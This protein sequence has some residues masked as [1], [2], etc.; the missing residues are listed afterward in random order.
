MEIQH[1]EQIVSVCQPIEQRMSDK[2]MVRDS[3]ICKVLLIRL[4]GGPPRGIA[5]EAIVW[6]VARVG[7]ALHATLGLDEML[8]AHHVAGVAQV[9]CHE[10]KH[11]S[12]RA[13]QHRL[14]QLLKTLEQG[15]PRLVG[16]GV[17]LHACAHKDPSLPLRPLAQYAVE[18]PDESALCRREWACV[19]EENQWHMVLQV[20][21]GLAPQPWVV[22][23]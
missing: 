22:A 15:C 18:A 9:A 4:P 12:P 3:A 19:V 5:M 10:K 23:P 17:V 14:C 20:L 7:L 16:E 21:W 1:V 13:W 6:H 8:E 2:R 11:S